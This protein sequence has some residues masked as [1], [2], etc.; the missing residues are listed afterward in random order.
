VRKAKVAT[1]ACFLDV[2]KAAAHE[3][4]GK[5][6]NFI[7]GKVM[8]GVGLSLPCHA[9][10]RQSSARVLSFNYDRLFE[11][12]FFGAFADE[13]V[14]SLGAYD[15]GALN[16]GVNAFGDCVEV[17]KDRFCFLKLHGSIGGLC[18]NPLL[19]GGTDFI[20]NVARWKGVAPT[21]A[22]FFSKAGY[23]EMASSPMIVF[24]YEKHYVVSGRE[25]EL[26]FRGYVQKVWDHAAA[27]LKE[28]T[29]IWVIGYSFDRTDCASLVDGIQL[30]E[31]CRRLVIQNLAPE[32]ERIER[33]LKVEFDVQIPIVKHPEQF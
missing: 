15:E 21:D 23:V 26:P 20:D 8:H 29:D 25:N 33:L 16:S 30:A 28:A 18:K 2:E 14:R 24:P 11:I 9:K 7:Q 31:N 22:V 3:Q 12:A 1:A 27:V 4:I 5:Y 19:G 10:L 32:C 13:H 17:K 6:R